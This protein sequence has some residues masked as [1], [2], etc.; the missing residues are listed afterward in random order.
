MAYAPARTFDD[1]RITMAVHDMTI[2]RR[3]SAGEYRV[4]FDNGD[5]ATAYYTD[6]LTDAR[7]TGILMSMERDRRRI[8]GPHAV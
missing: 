4:N 5:E 3:N 2:S 7:D 1:V 8:L 6:D